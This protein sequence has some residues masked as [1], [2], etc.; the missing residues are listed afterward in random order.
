MLIVY[1][2]TRRERKL[3]TE[4]WWLG[5]FTIR[6]FKDEQIRKVETDSS[7]KKDPKDKDSS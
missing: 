5:P 1:S 7:N 6:G 2:G 4:I 3:S